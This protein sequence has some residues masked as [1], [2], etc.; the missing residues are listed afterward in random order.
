MRRRDFLIDLTRFAALAA[1]V[2]NDWRVVHHPRFAD[3]PF[4]LGVASG[5]PT[6]DGVILWT[7]LAPRP[8][9]PFGG[10]EGSKVTVNWEV[11]N[12]EGFANIVAKGT[13]TGLPEVN[14]SIHVDVKGLEPARW[15]FYRFR[16]GGA[17][18]PV[19]RTRTAPAVGVRAPLTFAFASCQHYEHGYY[20]AYDYMAREELDLIAFLGDYIYEYG[21]NKSNPRLHTSPE[22][23]DLAGY[24]GR[25]TQYKLDPL[26][27]AA[28]ARCPWLLITD[29][30]EVDN[31]Y[32]NLI[33][34]NELESAEWMHARRAAAYQAWW[35]HQPVRTPVA[36]SWADLVQM[37]RVDWGDT[38]RVHLLDGRQYRSNQACGDNQREVPCGNW[39]DPKRTMLGDAQER[40]LSNG[41]ATSKHRWQI[42]ANQV[43]FAPVDIQP[44][45]KRTFHMDSWG[46]YPAASDRLLASIAKYAPNRTVAVSGDIHSAWVNELHDHFASE[47]SPIVAAEFV[48]TSITSDGDGEEH[49]KNFTDVTMS[50]NPHLK[51][52]NSR[53]GYSV[54]RV[55]GDVWN[56]E[57]RTLDYIS[58]P[59]SPIHTPTKWR[60]ERGRPGIVRA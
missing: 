48:G 34:E 8:L 20:T 50:E 18:S 27:Q 5:D 43:M 30:H 54:C 56:T 53:R 38:A 10:M 9:E 28:H 13:A 7:R 45:P 19:G 4:T 40:W 57:Y 47:K 31:N 35:E 23:M 58:K 37:R 55:D 2:P 59:G 51:W 21:P 29:D 36:N 14:Y 3:D 33:S 12:D 6:P 49:P 1:V 17:T 22:V 42:L 39:A 60:V 25:Y 46:G 32:A 15:Y 41:L 26:L 24:R 11:A 16:S 44:G 52:Q